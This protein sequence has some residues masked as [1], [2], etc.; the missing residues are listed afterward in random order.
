VG[1]R[2]GAVRRREDPA[3]AQARISLAGRI[4]VRAG[5]TVLDER[6]LPGRQPRVAFA[7]LVLERHRAVGLEELAGCLWGEQR[8][9]TWEPALRGVL[10]R[11]RA[12]VVASGLGGPELL[13]AEGGTYRLQHDAITVDVE[14]AATQVA[15]AEE[16]ARRGA[17][18]RAVEEA[19]AARGVLARPLLAG[20]HGEWLDGVRRDHGQLLLRALEVLAHAR[21][22]LGLAADAAATADA[23]LALD[24]YRE[25]V[26][27]VL[28]AAHAQTGNPAAGLLAYERCRALL[29]DELGVDPS[30]ETRALHVA[31]LERTS[32]PAEAATVPAG[33]VTTVPTTAGRPPGRTAP[34]P[35]AAAAPHPGSAGAPYVGLRTFEEVDADRFF[36]RDADVSR[37]LDRLEDTRLLAV[38]G[39]S[40]S[41][42]SSLVR[43][44]LVPALR[45]GA[46]PGAD[47][48]RIEVLRPGADP[49]GALRIVLDAGGADH[50]R[51]SL[52]VVDQLEEVFVLAPE[53]ERRPFLDAV[54][55]LASSPDEDV[56]V[57]VTLRS[58]LY[59]S[60][61]EHPRLADLA[62][63]HQ[64]LVTPLD[65]VG[66]AE[67]VE[68]PARHA[69][70]ALQPRLTETILR[71]VARR[72]AALPL[73]QQA[74]LELWRRRS[75]HTL[76]LDGYRDAG[77]I[78]AAIARW[79]ETVWHALDDDD[80]A[81]ARRVLLRL[82]RP[83]VGTEDSRLLVPVDQLPTAPAEVGQVE[84]V[85]NR[86]VEARV[87]TTG[88]APGGGERLVELS[89]EA[90]LRG[91]PR[92]RGWV[93]EDRAG[94]LVHR[95]LT[96]TAH[97]WDRRD[98]DP[99]LLYRGG[100][101]A[102]AAAWADREAA[103]PNE[104]E[105]GFLEASTAAVRAEEHRRVR[106]LQLTVVAL[107]LGV[108]ATG[109]LAL[110]GFAQA[111]RSASQQRIAT[112]REL[113]SAAVADLDADA[114]RSVLLA[115]E[116][117]GATREADGT[118]TRQ[119]EEA[120]HRAVLAH[121]TVGRIDRGGPSLA[122]TP[123]GSAVAIVDDGDVHLV[124]TDGTPLRTFD[125]GTERMSAVA[126]DG[127]GRRLAA[128]GEGGVVRVW[129]LDGDGPAQELRDGPLGTQG[130]A[131]SPDGRSL[132]A[133]GLDGAVR[134]WDLGAVDEPPRR[135]TGYPWGVFDVAF[136]TDGERL[137]VGGDDSAAWVFDVATE[138]VTLLRGHLW[139]VTGLA[140]S[141]D[142]AT[143]ATASSDGTARTWDAATGDPR[144]VFP[145][146]APVVSV[147][148]DP[149][150]DQLA[151]G[152]SDGSILVF[153]SD[154][155]RPILHLGGHAA[156]VEDVSFAP[157][158]D[159]LVSTSTDGTTR[160][161]NVGVGGGRDWLTAP[162]A[163]R[164]FA[165]V[166]FSPDG[167]WFAV[168]T[169][170]PNGVTLYDRE[171]GAVRAR[172]IGHDT[173]VTGVTVSPDGR[174]VVG[175][176]AAGAFWSDDVG[177]GDVPVWDVAS[178]QLR[179]LLRGHG[180]LP[181]AVAFAPDGREVATIDQAGVVRT[182]DLGTGERTSTSS[183]LG[184]TGIGLTYDTD[185]W[186]GLISHNDGVVELW[187][188]GADTP[189][190]R[191]IGHTARASA[192]DV[193]V[194]RLVTASQA[195]G[196]ARVWDPT[197]GA[198]LATVAGHG[199][200]LGQVAL[201]PSGTELATAGEDGVVRLWELPSGREL[202]ALHGHR[203]I[204]HGVDYS[205]DGELLAT[206]SPDGTV[207]L[208]LRSI[209]DLVEVARQR[210][211]RSL[212]DAECRRYLRQATCDG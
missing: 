56:V 116:A 162:S 89:H 140:V 80:R 123:D 18:D 179:T 84:A 10:S 151:I 109:A 133:G 27:R 196:T 2:A 8:P 88:T 16:A 113:A 91:W 173:G 161:W 20:A 101:L 175:T 174:S 65:E 33:A 62:S 203:L 3:V 129:A 55:H 51:R 155:A 17:P 50:D 114:E 79:A 125:A 183:A 81:V 6:A 70:L 127:E 32:T 119:A 147:A 57:V 180:D 95:R 96:D 45:A 169:D 19:A 150:G 37:L 210:L 153:E 189:S 25:S 130:L 40:G 97:E 206:S 204:A 182:W 64:Y 98:R 53:A 71:D 132:G 4:A 163:D 134:V 12:F 72:P 46:L 67:A 166:T 207:A 211:T 190:R 156:P 66:L 128:G 82:T 60:L 14:V 120:L 111:S 171:T 9:S 185:G 105:R 118:V 69:G 49:N 74:L 205:P 34:V 168:P 135:Y 164:R 63:A 181:S 106:R 144:S 43:A 152:A 13:H 5:R 99:A 184:Y 104:L 167:R 158:G 35:A 23:A 139:A 188:E 145:S 26:H 170:E 198:L 90:L 77:G 187:H 85:V 149:T 38:L 29:A 177:A 92:L 197:T 102:E 41:G 176:A 75:G 83:G 1:R 141:P 122:L 86:L 61:A 138:R 94:L 208:R 73:L 87:L 108:L 115:L 52:V 157:D 148:F 199:A 209:D 44:G 159:H 126:I 124:A 131:F 48:W 39:P 194:G 200:P 28:M 54:T 160:R 76:T 142:G 42:K 36:G 137:V 15:R 143:I 192:V 21:L 202:L 11:V 47:T 165:T 112:A 68:G 146:L 136:T 172:L 22:E 154:T 59:P 31:L 100:L 121:R 193:G 103:A 93:D 195:D 117:V 186:V 7:L 24:A 191:L 201:H 78:E 58:D 107:L 110:F 212:D 30:P 178:G